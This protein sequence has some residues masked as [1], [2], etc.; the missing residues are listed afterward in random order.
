[1]LPKASMVLSA[2]AMA[3]GLAVFAQPGVEAQ[4]GNTIYACVNNSSGAVKIVAPG[5]TCNN[6]E[7]LRTWNIVGPAGPAGPAGPEGPAGP[8]GTNGADGAQGPGGPGSP[9]AP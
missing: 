4:A 7:T 1:M 2:I 9:C 5:A 3:F 8:P 6:N